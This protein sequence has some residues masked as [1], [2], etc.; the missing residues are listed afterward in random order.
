V[1]RVCRTVGVHWVALTED[2]P[3]GTRPIKT[4]KEGTPGAGHEKLAA[5]PAQLRQVVALLGEGLAQGG[6]GIG[7]GIVYTPGAGH[8]EM[9][10][11]IKAVG[12]HGVALFVHI[13]GQAGRL[14]LED[15][16]EMFAGAAA[17][18][19][20]VHICHSLSSGRTFGLSSWRDIL[21]M[22]TVSAATSCAGVSRGEALCALTG[23]GGAARGGRCRGST[24]RVLTSRSSST[25]IHTA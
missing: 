2:C 5:S 8:Q 19:A 12:Q 18:G 17:A 16:H 4:C 14:G 1:C 22:A 7:A 10:R 25:R 3:Y 9:Y 13:R 24:S 15:F 20:A 11:V 23:R 21:D 6:I